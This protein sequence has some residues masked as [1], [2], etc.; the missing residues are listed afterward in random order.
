M[1]PPFPIATTSTA[2]SGAGWPFRWARPLPAIV[3]AGVAAAA[4]LIVVYGLDRRPAELATVEETVL[5]AQLPLLREY[6]VVERLDL[7][8]DLDAI[9]ELDRLGNG[10]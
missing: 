1:P 9:R 7:L 5:G 8:E 4:L 3:T 2:R 10:G 6:R